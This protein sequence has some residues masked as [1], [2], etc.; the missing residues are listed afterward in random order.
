MD[1]RATVEEIRLH[2]E[3]ATGDLL[4]I[5]SEYFFPTEAVVS[6]KF[7]VRVVYGRN[8]YW[9]ENPNQGI[10]A[11]FNLKSNLQTCILFLEYY[12]H[13]MLS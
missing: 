9:W 8:S 2:L 12:S 6:Y 1:V 11:K 3:R 4:G 10:S 7:N 13:N 5:D